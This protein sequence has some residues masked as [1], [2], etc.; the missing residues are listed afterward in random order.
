M[1]RTK[2]NNYAL[3]QAKATEWYLRDGKGF[4]V[5]EDKKNCVIYL[6]PDGVILYAIPREKFVLDPDKFRPIYIGTD[7]E[8]GAKRVVAGDIFDEE[9]RKVRI[10]EFENG[11]TVHINEKFYTEF[12][13]VYGEF[14]QRGEV[15][16]YAQGPNAPVMFV[17][18][19]TVLGLILPIRH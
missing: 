9:Y 2:S 19:G 17:R 4:Y 18:N 11:K 8:A 16:A 13:K 1:A 10:F 14:F 7:L 6:T 3:P 15:T 12:Q 5:K